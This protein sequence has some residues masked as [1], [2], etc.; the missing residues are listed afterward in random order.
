MPEYFCVS[1]FAVKNKKNLDELHRVFSDRL[2][3]PPGK[4][5]VEE[6]NFS[7]LRER[8]VALFVYSD[9]GTDYVEALVGFPYQLFHKESFC[10]ELESLT[11]FVDFCF[12][13]SDEILYAL[14]S[15][16][17]NEYFLRDTD[18]LREFD[19]EIINKFPIAFV[20]KGTVVGLS[21]TKELK[22][23]NLLVNHKAQDLFS[24]M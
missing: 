14:C 10:V 20:K 7:M 11:Q 2:G 13:L 12:G 9:K 22:H 16:E 8:K 24:V 23:S 17:C 1:F 15:Y 6:S 18:L 4:S 5:Y 3:I 19:C 21:P